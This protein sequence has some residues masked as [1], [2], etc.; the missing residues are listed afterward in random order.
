M[1]ADKEK[2]MKYE[3][4]QDRKVDQRM[5]DRIKS[6][7]VL[8][9]QKNASKKE[10]EKKLVELMKM[11]NEQLKQQ[12]MAA[13]HNQAKEEKKMQREYAKI[14]EKQA[15]MH[16]AQQKKFHDK[17]QASAD[18]MDEYV[19]KEQAAK[20]ASAAA[21]EAATK[22]QI[23]KDKEAYRDQMMAD[24]AKASKKK[25]DEKKMFK[26]ALT[27]QLNFKGEQERLAREEQ[28]AAMRNLKKE[29]K[30]AADKE[31]EKA[32]KIREANFRNKT[33]LD[34]Q[35]REKQ[36]NRERQRWMSETE[37]QMNMNLIKKVEQNH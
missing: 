32:C 29:L 22:D 4:E 9:Q 14:L 7:M 2:L 8:E 37:L 24:A 11:Q 31:D 33:A 34:A 20:G 10:E 23:I 25:E 21:D 3:F 1:L 30:I 19:K 17:I 12:K 35:I 36:A 13:K 26:A 15:E 27:E 28:K 5:L 16:A 18:R 6:E